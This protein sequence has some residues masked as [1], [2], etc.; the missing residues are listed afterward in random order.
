MATF[1]YTASRKIKSGHSAGTDYTITIGLQQ[2]DDGMPSAVK[3]VHKSLGGRQVTTLHRVERY[4]DIVTDY[5]PVT[6][7][8]PDAED[9]EEFFF[10]VAA[11]ETFTFNGEGADD[12]SVMVGKPQRIR[13]GLHYFYRFRIQT[14]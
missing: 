13:Q 5:I 14:D 1:E 9:F 7:G 4:L 2:L 10:S 11:G 6:G 8:T 12:V 3:T